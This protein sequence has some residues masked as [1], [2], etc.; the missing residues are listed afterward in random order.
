MSTI[1]SRLTTDHIDDWNEYVFKQQASIYHDSRW[2][3]LIKKVFGHESHYLMAVENG[4]VVGIFPL[5]QLKS[6]LFGNF[7]I[8]MPYFNYGGA[9]ADTQEIMISL[10]SSAHE[11]SD[12]LG[13]SHIEMRFD[14]EQTIELPTRTD[15]II[16]LLD[17]PDDPEEL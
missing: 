13:C 7:L 5:V 8:S 4:K 16:I 2:S 1:V 10:I 11:L 3:Q 9:I 15:K 17:L 12:E 14:S 6:M